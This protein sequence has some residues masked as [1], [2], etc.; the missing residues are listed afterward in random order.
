MAA[1]WSEDELLTER[2]V[3]PMRPV[4][5]TKTLAHDLD[6]ETA[7]LGAMLVDDRRAAEAF[8]VVDADDFY[9]PAH[10]HIFDAIV[11]VIA[12][13]AKAD[14]VTVADQLRRSDM[15]EMV[16]GPSVLTDMQANTPVIGNLRPYAEIVA[17][18]AVV[19]GMQGAV[20]E[21][22]SALD[23]RDIAGAT[24][25]IE[26]A[27]NLAAEDGADELEF[28]DVGAVMRGEVDGIQPTMLRRT[29]GNCLIYP[30]LLHWLM[31]EPGK[32]KTWAALYV[33]AE[34]LTDGGTVVYLDW[35]G[36]RL[37]VGSRLMALGV[38]AHVVDDRLIYLRPKPFTNAS[39]A[40]LAAVVENRCAD[41]VVGDG[42]A[43]ALARQG[44]NEDKASD[45]LAWLELVITPMCEAGAAVLLLDHVAKDK[46]SRAQWARGSGAKI[47][48]VSGAAWMVKPR[49][50][51]SR[52][53]PGEFDLIQAK[54]REGFNAAD[55]ETV[56][57]FRVTPHNEGA[58]LEVVVDPAPSAD[59][60]GAGDHAAWDGPTEC[61]EA[62]IEVLQAAPGVEFAKSHLVEALRATGKQ[63]RDRTI[64]EA[65]QRLVLEG[66]C[67]FRRGPRNS[68]LYSWRKG[69][70][71]EAV[72]LT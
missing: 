42:T 56:A 64:G 51:F 55:G 45:V 63:Y 70:Q 46:E 11:A 36:N 57:R 1:Q 2:P 58:Q 28:E 71:T 66:R 16:G 24:K 53:N 72:E 32:G 19:R 31:G 34:V 10:G 37:I 13:G 22:A 69:A 35:E 43:K 50:L 61:M 14:P 7:L 27:R 47:G 9:K 60:Q 68:Q 40:A 21:A 5:S 15:L 62:V 4:V 49:R 29:D 54:D 30:G 3:A 23:K 38:P 41:I 17:R 59:T 26:R 8:E 39:A 48:E 65:A 18:Y 25:N 12:S 67:S 6:A 20:A 44:M 33:T 52:K